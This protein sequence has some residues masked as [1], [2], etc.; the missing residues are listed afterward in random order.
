M[1]ELTVETRLP[2]EAKNAGFFISRGMGVHPDRIINTY[3][4]IFVTQGRLSLIEGNRVFEVDEGESLILWPHRRH[5]GV[6]AFHPDLRFYWLHFSLTERDA[7]D[8]LAVPQHVRV[9]RPDHLTSLFRRFLDDQEGRTLSPFA[10]NLQVMLMLAEVAGS[11]RDDAD[12]DESAATLA[13]RVNALIRTRYHEKLTTSGIART[14]HRNPDYLGR[15]YRGVTG[16]TITEAIHLYRLKR[17]RR[18]LLESQLTVEAIALTCGYRDAGYF[19]R[20][21]KRAEGIPPRRFKQLHAKL[22]VN[23]G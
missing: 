19:R 8:D 13:N 18:L 9:G 4:L 6:S 16:V 7:G 22:H 5:R 21:F 3:E 12:G 1:N 14:L 20:L 17:A 23:T 10:A 2:L 15:V 11:H